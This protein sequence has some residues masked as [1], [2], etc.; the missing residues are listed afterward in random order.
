MNERLNDRLRRATAEATAQG[1]AAMVVAPSPD[2]AYLTG[3]EPMPMERPTLLVL[4]DDRDPVML[5]PELEQPLA[6][7]SS[8]GAVVELVGWSDGDD[9]YTAAA[10][11]LEP[12]GRVAVGDR[13][14]ASHVLGLQ[15]V[16]PGLTFEPASPVIGRLRAVKDDDELAAL[17]RAAR[18]ADETFRQICSSTFLGRREEEIAADLADL[19]VE[20]GH[21]YADFTIVASG[22]NSASPHHEPSGRTI[23]PRDVVVMDFGG[24]LGGYFSDTTR[25][26]VVGE[27]PNGF[28]RVYDTVRRAQEAACEAVRPG[29]P[30]QDVDR[31]ARQI[32][33]DAGLGARFIHRTG[34]GIGREVHEPP[35]IV[36]GNEWVLEPGTTFSVEPGV[37]LQDS[38]GVRI[39]DIVAVTEDGV[40]RLNRSTR[41]LKVVN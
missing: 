7:A 26:V 21:A 40:E 20:H 28:E 22:P 34:H 16:L 11:L 41:E 15:E 10:H 3:Y 17:R 29:V 6:A 35:Y 19:L 14:W 39:E 30:C 33:D 25:T 12:Q 31:A 8:A 4:R 24:E 38:F 32:I 9:P 2:L 36:E 1:F 37:Y 27:P 5:V 13:L 23:L 18:G